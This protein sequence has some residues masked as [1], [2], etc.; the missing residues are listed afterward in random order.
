MAAGLKQIKARIRS[1]KNTRKVTKAMELVAG[2]K[3]RRAVDRAIG[4]RQYAQLAWDI[5]N[6]L[7]SSQSIAAIDYLH[8]FF[9]PAK[10]PKKFIVVV[11]ASNRGLCGA[12]NSNI[13]KKV[14]RFVKEKGVENVEVV[15]V[16][17]RAV[18]GLSIFGI[19]AKMAYEKDD[20]APDASSIVNVANYVYEEFKAGRAD[21]VLIAYNHFV[22]SL[23]QEP[24]I[25]PLFPFNREE[26]V[27]STIDEL[28]EKR[29]SPVAA[30]SMQASSLV[31]YVHDPSKRQVLSYIVPRLGELQLYQAL[32]ESNASEHSARMI[33]MKNS[34]DAAGEMQEN[35]TLQFNR[36]RQAAITQ[37]IAEISA[38][39]AAIS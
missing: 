1:V 30:E 22:S 26:G 27:S 36:A 8:N 15:A 3:M 12:Y 6:R 10:D 31:D 4:T 14:A 18:T 25:K 35:L 11:Y 17:K 23:V 39:M 5:A 13:A 20:S 2:A 21:Q 29:E 28:S 37:E 38:G 32:L 33:A 24:A 16:G 7:S 34:T 9:V 19:N